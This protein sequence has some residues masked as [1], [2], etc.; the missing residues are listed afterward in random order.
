MRYWQQKG[1]Y[2][3]ELKALTDKLIPSMGK[4]PT[5]HGELLRLYNRFAYDVYNNGLCNTDSLGDLFEELIRRADDIELT[6]NATDLIGSLD[7]LMTA[8]KENGDKS[9]FPDYDCDCD[10]DDDEDNECYCDDRSE[11][12][13]HWDDEVAPLFEAV[14]ENDNGISDLGD[15]ILER[16]IS[17]ENGL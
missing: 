9:N 6:Q 13:I 7:K 2:Q 16:V 4:A 14:T 11:K 17:I 10:I 15:C 3:K 8:I 5:D 1:K 12:D